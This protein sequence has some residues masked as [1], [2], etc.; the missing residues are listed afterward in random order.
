[1]LLFLP[2]AILVLTLLALIASNLQRGFHSNWLL[3]LGGASLAWL[4]LFYLRLQ[5]PLTFTFPFFWASEGLEYSVTFVLDEVSWSLAFVIGG[6]LLAALLEEV[7]QAM[8]ATWLSWGLALL[9]AAGSMLAF[10]SGDAL[11]FI[12]TWTL[13]DVVVYLFLFASLHGEEE[14][15][16]TLQMI[17]VNLLAT[18][19]LLAAWTLSFYGQQ[20]NQILLILAAA[21][22][23]GLLTPRLVFRPPSN[24]RNDLAGMLLLAP[25]GAVLPL[26]VRA[27]VLVEPSASIL[28]VLVFLPTAYSASTWL[29]GPMD[30][31]RRYWE[32]GSA[33][34]VAA[35]AISGQGQAALAFGL[36]ILMG[37]GLLPLVQQGGR[38]RLLLAALGVLLLSG[39]QFTASNWTAALYTNSTTPLVLA[40]LF[41]QSAMVAG[42]LRRALD[43][44]AVPLPPEPWM[45]TTQRLGQFVIPA[46]YV[47]FGLGLLPSLSPLP[48]Q[49]PLWPALA[50]TGGAGLLFLLQR[51]A[52]LRFNPRI[53]SA[54]QSVSSLTWLA[55]T[56]EQ[57]GVF[58][59]TAM[60]FL[61]NLLE[62]KAGVLWAMLVMALLLSLVGQFGV[63]G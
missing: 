34:L 41:I 31:S 17:P 5:F 12:L 8:S 63:G 27:T 2:V 13:L 38:F 62:G 24:L 44:K 58:L 46:I 22:R 37:R 10:S 21:L 45:R 3:A 11:T 25:L 61:S 60:S 7:R 19:L 53:S 54:L 15:R 35:A 29:L 55:W 49:P 1:M 56:V 50:V 4:S 48:S 20:L 52:R 59:S 16:A 57:M 42:W 18:F 26:L 51:G 30:G 39:L 23:V 32:L 14:R 47:V 43:E 33:G 36:L 40:F 9:A 28:L 6:L